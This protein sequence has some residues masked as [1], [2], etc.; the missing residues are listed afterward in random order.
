V[1][2]GRYG[3]GQISGQNHIKGNEW[4]FEAH[5]YQDPVMPGSLG[6]EALLQTLKAAAYERWPD[7]QAF[8]LAPLTEHQWTYR[9]QVIRQPSE[10]DFVLHI[11]EED[12]QRQRLVA[13]GILYRDGLPIYEIKN[14]SLEA[15]QA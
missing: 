7:A 10:L 8:V 9:G 1:R 4:Y 11:K 14:L 5:F 15:W 2:G 6:L 3:L 13:D 12:H